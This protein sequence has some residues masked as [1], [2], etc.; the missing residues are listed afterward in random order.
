MIKI[1]YKYYTGGPSTTVDRSPTSEV[2]YQTL[3]NYK[4]QI[5]KKLKT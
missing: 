5:I 4:Q 1:I 3:L 2:R